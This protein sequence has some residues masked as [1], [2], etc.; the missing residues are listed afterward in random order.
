MELNNYEDPATDPYAPDPRASQKLAAKKRA[1]AA[2]PGRPTHETEPITPLQLSRRYVPFGVGAAVLILLMIG[3]ASWQLGHTPAKPLQIETAPP[4]ASG[5]GVAVFAAPTSTPVLTQI[6]RAT[7]IAPQNGAGEA[8][9]A[10]EEGSQTGRGMTVDLVAATLTPEPPAEP[11][12]S[13]IDN[14][15]AQAPHS[16]R[17]GLCGPTGGDC[18]PAVPYGIDNSQYIANVGEQVPHKVR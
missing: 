10:S 17:G 8:T 6:P 14:V 16:P 9:G 11:T 5:S 18:A 2:T 15:G 3:M 4:T 7:P 1:A 13:Y 12:P